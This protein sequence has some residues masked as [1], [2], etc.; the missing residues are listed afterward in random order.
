MLLKD[1]REHAG[2]SKFSGYDQKGRVLAAALWLLSL[3][4]GHDEEAGDAVDGPGW[5]A[6][7]HRSHR[8]TSFVLSV[9]PSGFVDISTHPSR[10]VLAVWERIVRDLEGEEEKGGCD[11]FS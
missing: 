4:S 10:K 7:F 3:E 11:R 6:L 9:S 5:F 8:P 1:A 2:S